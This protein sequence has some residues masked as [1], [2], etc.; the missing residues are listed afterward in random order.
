MKWVSRQGSRSL[1]VA[2]S[3]VSDKNAC[4]KKDY[5]AASTCMCSEAVS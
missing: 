2:G 1:K 3:N 4:N 5:H